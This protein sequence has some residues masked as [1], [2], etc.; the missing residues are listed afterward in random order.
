MSTGLDDFGWCMPS[1]ILQSTK[2]AICRYSTLTIPLLLRIDGT[3]AGGSK[4][5][6][7]Y[8][9]TSHRRTLRGSEVRPSL[10]HNPREVEQR[11]RI[12]HP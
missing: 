10:D 5:Q 4:G 8:Q 6:E 12:G 9:D 11:L 7:R 1:Y 3:S 2:A